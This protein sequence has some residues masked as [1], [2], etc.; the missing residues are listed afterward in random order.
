MIMANL[1]VLLNFSGSVLLGTSSQFGAAASWGGAL[2]RKDKYWRWLN[3]LGWF[4]LVLG[5][6][7]QLFAA[8]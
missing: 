6:G 2:D 5:F 1:G 7:I 8:Y 3:I 4:L